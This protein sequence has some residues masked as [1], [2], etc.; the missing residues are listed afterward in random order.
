MEGCWLLS[1]SLSASRG[2]YLLA[3]LTVGSVLCNLEEHKFQNSSSFQIPLGQAKIICQI[4]IM[5]HKACLKV[6]TSNGP[7]SGKLSDSLNK[8]FQKSVMRRHKS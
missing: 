8:V 6:L 3:N 2:K 5:V 4:E 1:T 7:L